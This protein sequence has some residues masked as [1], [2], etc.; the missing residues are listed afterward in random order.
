MNNAAIRRQL[1]SDM[2][3]AQRR[4]GERNRDNLN[5]AIQVRNEKAY[6]FAKMVRERQTGEAIPEGWDL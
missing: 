1:G 6:Q 2:I 3:E 5:R 4:F